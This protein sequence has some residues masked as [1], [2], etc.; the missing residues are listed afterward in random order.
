MRM[1]PRRRRLH[2]GLLATAVALTSAG[3]ADATPEA[4]VAATVTDDAGRTVALPAPAQRVFSVIPSITETLAELDADALIARTRFDRDPALEDLPVLGGTINPN[5]EALARLRPDLVVA[6]LDSGQRSVADRIE[7]LGIPVYRANVETI[8]DVRRHMQKLGILL[9]RAEEADALV[10]EL[11]AELDRVS[12]AVA[13]LQT[14][15]VY[16]S[17]WHDPPQS[18]GPGTFIDEVIRRAGGRNVFEDA[19]TAWPQ[20]SLEEI[21]HRQPDVLVIARHEGGSIDAPWLEGVGWREL[22]AVRERR[23]LVVDGDLFNRPGP[24]V[25]E[26]ARRMAIFLHGPDVLGPT[27]P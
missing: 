18:T 14:V 16:Y 22:A 5:I 2:S 24:R 9:D 10:A 3:C 4:P 21:V 12:A 23:F 7:A 25:A 27:R 6:F 15:D 20:V 26:A 19:P 8:D 17:V 13:G 11:D 1:G